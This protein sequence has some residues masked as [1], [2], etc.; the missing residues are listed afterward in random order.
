MARCAITVEMAYG[1]DVESPAFASRRELPVFGTVG[2]HVLGYPARRIAPP[3]EF[4]G[5]ELL[6]RYDTLRARID[7]RNPKWFEPIAAA[8]LA[9]RTG[10][11][12]PGDNFMLDLVLAESELDAHRAN[13]TART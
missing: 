5:E 3:Y 10:C 9:F 8:I 4:Q 7:Q 11:E 6:T 1:G 12:L 2:M 13:K